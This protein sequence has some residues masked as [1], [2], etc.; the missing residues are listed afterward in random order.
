MAPTDPPADQTFALDTHALGSQPGHGDAQR[1]SYRRFQ[2]VLSVASVAVGVFYLVRADRD[3]FFGGAFLL[4]GVMQALQVAGLLSRVP[5]AP[6]YALS[7]AGVRYHVTGATERRAAWA[8]IE[9]V[10]HRAGRIEIAV[11]DGQPIVVPF[12]AASY[13]DAQAMK[14]AT[15]AW[16]RHKQIPVS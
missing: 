11:R 7:G 2:I 13:A 12:S 4:L 1:A 3:L 14:A 5:A 10:T 15:D 9:E 6:A 8:D 16:A